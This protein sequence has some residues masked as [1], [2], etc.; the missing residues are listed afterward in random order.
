MSDLQN[1]FENVGLTGHQLTTAEQTALSCSLAVL[2][3]DFSTPVVFWGKVDGYQGEYLIAQTRSNGPGMS[4]EQAALGKEKTLFSTDRGHNWTLLESD[5]T[6]KQTQFAE[7]IR[8]K[9]MGNPKHDYKVKQQ[10]PDLEEP[11]APVEPAADKEADG[12]D[13]DEEKEENEG[14]KE[15]EEEKKEEAAEEEAPKKRKKKVV[16]VS[17]AESTRLAHFVLTH[18]FRCKVVPHGK[19]MLTQ[20]NTVAINKTFHGLTREDAIL[21]SRYC[22]LRKPRAAK[23]EGG[24]P[25]LDFMEPLSNDIPQGTWTLQYDPSLGL[26]VGKNLMFPVWTTSV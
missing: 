16:I 14:E 8:G 4:V 13:E 5:L 17:M 12:E 9:F 11:P 19:L 22:H 10:L 7:Q 26:V 24:N 20:M 15:E 23:E 18:D 25:V 1:S 2:S 21:P 3:H 6:D